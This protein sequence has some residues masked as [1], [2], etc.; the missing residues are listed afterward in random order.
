MAYQLI[1][2]KC[3]WKIIRIL[4]TISRAYVTLEPQVDRN[5]DEKSLKSAYR[6]VFQSQKKNIDFHLY[7]ARLTY[8]SLSP[9]S[10]SLWFMRQTILLSRR[11]RSLKL[12]PDKGGDNQSF[13]CLNRAYVVLR[14]VIHLSHS[15][16]QHTHIHTHQ[17]ETRNEETNMT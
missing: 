5:A 9:L 1:H 2:T 6:Y 7:C 13:Q 14:Y 10:L 3:H 16:L 4:K 8:L 12:H 17:T 11:K 15:A